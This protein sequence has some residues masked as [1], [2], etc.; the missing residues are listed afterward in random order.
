MGCKEMHMRDG[1]RIEVVDGRLSVPDNPIIPFIEGDG[2][3]SD[4]TPAMRRVLDAA[5]NRAYKGSRRLVWYEI[6]AGDKAEERYGTRL[7]Q[8]TIEA[9]RDCKVAIKGPLAT[10]VG[11]G[12]RSLNVTL[13]Q[14]LDLYACVRPIRYIQGIPSP[15]RNPERIDMVVF[16][17]NT[18]DLYAGIEWKAGTAENEL[19]RQFLNGRMGCSIREGS[20]IG[21]KPISEFGTKRLARKAIRY[22]LDHGRRSVTIMHKG[23][24]MKYTEGSFREWCYEVA[25]SEFSNETIT[26]AEMENHDLPSKGKIVIKDRIADAMFQ[27]VLLWPDQHEVIVAPNVNGD[28]LSDALAAQ[29]GGLGIAPGSNIGDNI[30]LFEATHGTAPM[31]AGMD[32]ANPTSIILSGALLLEF[33]G[34]DKAAT[35]V[36]RGI[37]ETIAQKIVTFDLASRLEGAR[38]VRCSEFAEAVV[39]AISGEAED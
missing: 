24:I 12:H 22:A 7:P 29:V 39:E 15:M 35:L 14:A 28:Y 18:E 21:I 11:G 20:G 8:E 1:E 33:I 19:V 34:W 30:G 23:N 2:I 26:E 27:E 16:R 31:F 36:R 37:E 25:A 6:Y 17:E 38:E 32:K 13:R 10:P 9:I 4:I 5:V 3:G